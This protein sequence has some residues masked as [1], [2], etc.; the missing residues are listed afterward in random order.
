MGCLLTRFNAF[1]RSFLAF[2]HPS[3]YQTV[4]FF[5]NSGFTF[6]DGFIS[7]VY[8]HVCE[9]TDRVVSVKNGFD[10]ELRIGFVVESIPIRFRKL[11]AAVCLTQRSYVA[12]NLYRKM[13]A[14]TEI[15]MEKSK[16]NLSTEMGHIY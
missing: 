6:R 14:S 5:Y 11:P 2:L 15:R 7:Y 3:L 8:K 12:C 1:L 10:T 4:L 9:L 16:K 13:I